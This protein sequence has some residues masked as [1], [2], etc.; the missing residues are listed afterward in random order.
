M[1]IS[2]GISSVLGF[3]VAGFSEL[4]QF[5]T[6]NRSAQWRDVGIDFGGY[7]TT[8]VIFLICV[9][10]WELIKYLARRRKNKVKKE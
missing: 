1:L 2:L 8:I 5:Y 7:M 3:C 6:P 10:I 9:G 4:A